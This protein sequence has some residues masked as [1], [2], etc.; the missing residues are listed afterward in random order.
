MPLITRLY[1]PSAFGIYSAFTNLVTLF[2]A[3]ACLRYDFALPV[4]RDGKERLTLLWLCLLI[5]PITALVVAALVGGFR[6]FAPSLPLI[7]SVGPIAWF[8]PLGAATM[9]INNAGTYWAIAEKEFRAVAF[10]SVYQAVGMN[11]FQL[12]GGLTAAVAPTLAIGA[13]VG[14]AVGIVPLYRL[15]R[16]RAPSWPREERL[17]PAAS[18]ARAYKKFPLLT[19]WSSLLNTASLTFPSLALLSL[20]GASV[21]GYY[22]LAYGVI[23]RPMGLVVSSIMPVY[24]SRAAELAAN[25]VRD[26]KKLYYSLLTRLSAAS[27]CATPLILLFPWVFKF[28]FGRSY[29]DAGLYAALLGITGLLNL[30]AN[31]TNGLIVLGYNAW[32]SVWEAS[33][34]FLLVGA[35]YTCHAIHRSAMEAVLAVSVVLGVFYAILIVMN[36]VMLNRLHAARKIPT[37]QEAFLIGEMEAAVELE[38]VEL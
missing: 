4:S 23:S 37:P 18:V 17:E 2:S 16:Q 13:V 11:I 7:S 35:L 8:I 32:M 34:L 28:V 15:M 22:A 29:A 5:T 1:V 20:Y 31:S 3:I 38:G 33:R 6:S 26:L 36:I 30:I 24:I 10:S 12:A 14:Q 9:G 21:N 27:I 19:S 25:D